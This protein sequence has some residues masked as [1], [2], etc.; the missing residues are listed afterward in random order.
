MKINFNTNFFSIDL[1]LER[2]VYW[3]YRKDYSLY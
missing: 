2:Q 1:L 3:K